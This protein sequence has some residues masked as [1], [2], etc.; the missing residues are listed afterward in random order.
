MRLALAA[1]A[2]LCLAT[3][4]ALSAQHDMHNMKKEDKSHAA[5]ES[6]KLPAGWKA[7]LDDAKANVKDIKFHKMGNAL[8]FMTRPATVVWNPANRA[9]GNFS[10]SGEFELMKKPEHPEAYG[11]VFAAENLDKAD[12]SYLYFLIRHDGRFLI[13]HRQGD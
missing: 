5:M 13:K 2:L 10:V 9:K 8:H 1:T 6:G 11:L 3:P 12:Q 4:L 7:R